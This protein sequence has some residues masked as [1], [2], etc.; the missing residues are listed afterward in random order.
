LYGVFAENAIINPLDKISSTKYHTL[1]AVF[2]KTTSIFFFVLTG[3]VFKKQGQELIS[4]PIKKERLN[5]LRTKKDELAKRFLEDPKERSREYH[6][7]RL[8][9]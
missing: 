1:F 5:V 7:Y 4:Q 3:T 8:S 6:D 9:S 2:F